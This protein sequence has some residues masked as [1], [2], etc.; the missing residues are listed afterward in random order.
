MTMFRRIP[1]TILL[2]GLAN[3]SLLAQSYQSSRSSFSDVKFDGPKGPASFAAGVE[4][5]AASGATSMSI[6]FGP[7][8][9]ER[10]LKFRLTL[11]MRLS[12]Q[13]G[14]SSADE[15]ALLYTWGAGQV[16]G[17]NTVDNGNTQTT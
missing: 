9:G 5:D 15:N 4:V 17:T 8:I 12:P 2:A 11:S 7:G 13:L 6:P 1:L 3:L 14:I 16:W 10:G